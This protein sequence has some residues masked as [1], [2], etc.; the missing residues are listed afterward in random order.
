MKA[1]TNMSTSAYMHTPED[2]FNPAGVDGKGHN[3]L[4]I[5][6]VSPCTRCRLKPLTWQAAYEATCPNRHPSSWRLSWNSFGLCDHNSCETCPLAKAFEGNEK[7]R[8]Y[9]PGIVRIDDQGRPNLMHKQRRGWGEYS[10]WYKDWATLL[11]KWEI[12]VVGKGADEHGEFIK[13]EPT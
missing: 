6:A 10:I 13:V 1:R 5:L 7:N 2:T 3:R 8:L 12:C 11:A 9:G 4:A